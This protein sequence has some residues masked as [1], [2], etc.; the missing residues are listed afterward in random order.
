VGQ[1]FEVAL[2]G[3]EA[4]DA[5]DVKKPKPTG[6]L[7]TADVEDAARVEQLL[8]VTHEK[9]A[10]KVEWTHEPNRRTHTFAVRGIQ[11]GEDP[12]KLQLRWD[13]HAIGVEKRL[14][15]EVAVAGLNTF[16]VDQAPAVRGK[17]QYLELRFTDPLKTPQNLNVLIQIGQRG[18]RLLAISG[19]VVSV[20]SA[21]SFLG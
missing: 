4:T 2:D 3:R 21:R 7:V 10:L 20:C 6:T 9:Q 14:A 19:G 17:E 12:S 8:Q 11:R 13:G 18:R 15:Q 1:A 5:Q 16:T